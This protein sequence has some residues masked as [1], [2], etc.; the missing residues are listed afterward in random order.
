M[1]AEA[2]IE[3]NFDWIDFQEELE[4]VLIYLLDHMNL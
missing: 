2:L 3:I 1:L 4:K